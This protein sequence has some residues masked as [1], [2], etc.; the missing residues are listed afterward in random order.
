MQEV[1]KEKILKWRLKNAE[2]QELHLFVQQFSMEALHHTMLNNNCQVLTMYDEMSVMYGQLEHSGSRLDPV[3]SLQW[4][5]VVK[6]FQNREQ[7]TAKMQHTAFNMCGF[8]QPTFIVNMLDGP[9][10]D[11]FNDR[12]FYICPE[13]VEYMY[14]DLR[15]PLDP[16]AASLKKS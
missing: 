8:I 2:L 1:E 14:N 15:V 4:W 16:S 10:P 11:A 12:Q 6:K 3:R 13:E 7:A 9:D 5:I